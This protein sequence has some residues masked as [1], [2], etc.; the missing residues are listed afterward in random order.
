MLLARHGIVAT[1][2]DAERL[3]YGRFLLLLAIEDAAM[4][5]EVAQAL[6]GGE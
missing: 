1:L 2:E 5:D 6:R 3:P 4:A